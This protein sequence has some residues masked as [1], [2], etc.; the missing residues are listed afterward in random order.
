MDWKQLNFIC[1]LKDQI[2][3]FDEIPS[4]HTFKDPKVIY[5]GIFGIGSKT[6]VTNLCFTIMSEF[7]DV[8]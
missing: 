3:E 2:Y 5:H 6:A 1:I 8:T 7:I 4:F